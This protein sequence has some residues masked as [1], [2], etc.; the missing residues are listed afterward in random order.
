MGIVD[1]TLNIIEI[2]IDMNYLMKIISPHRIDKK[3]SNTY[4]NL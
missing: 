2:G 1:K 3:L 4:A